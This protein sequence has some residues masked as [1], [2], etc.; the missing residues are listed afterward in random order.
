MRFAINRDLT[1]YAVQGEPAAVDSIAVATDKATK[2]R[3]FFNVFVERVKPVN[4]ICM[5]AMPVRAR[6]VKAI[7]RSRSCHPV[8]RASIA[9]PGT[10]W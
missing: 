2:V 1:V 7:S 3:T 5:P 6:A 8:S 9:W 10:A 4:D